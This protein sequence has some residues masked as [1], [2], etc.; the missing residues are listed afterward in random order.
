M[1]AWMNKDALDIAAIDSAD[2]L[3]RSTGL[4]S[5]WDIPSSAHRKFQPYNRNFGVW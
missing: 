1:L 3:A 2:P 4:P 5:S